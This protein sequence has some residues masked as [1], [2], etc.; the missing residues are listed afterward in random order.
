MEK[1]GAAEFGYLITETDLAKL[2]FFGDDYLVQRVEIETARKFKTEA[3]H[4]YIGKAIEL[5]TINTTNI[6]IGE[7]SGYKMPYSFQS[8]INPGKFEEVPEE[9]D[10]DSIEAIKKRQHEAWKRLGGAK[11]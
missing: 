2:D 10:E 5:L 11:K 4:D 6:S 9:K 7:H 1:F 8:Y 3:F